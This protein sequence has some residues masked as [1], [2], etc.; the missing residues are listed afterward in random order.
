MER[1]ADLAIHFKVPG[2]VS[3]NKFD[4]NQSK[5]EAI[6]QLA[7]DKFMKVLPRVPFDPVFTKSMIQG[8]NIFEYDNSSAAAKAVKDIWRQIIKNI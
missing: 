6:E 2:M 5:A 3:V 7:R 8:Q 4:L 1:V